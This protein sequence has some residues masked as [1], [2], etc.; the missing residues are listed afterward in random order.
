MSKKLQRQ[1]SAELKA[2]A[3]KMVTSP[4]SGLKPPPLGG[5]IY[6]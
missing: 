3:V 2:S 5:Q 6:L 1:Y 4:Y